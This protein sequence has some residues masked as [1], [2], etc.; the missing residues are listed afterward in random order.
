MTIKMQLRIQ[1]APKTYNPSMF[2]PKDLWK[3]IYDSTRLTIKGV[4]RTGW[5]FRNRKETLP[6]KEVFFNFNDGRLYD[7]L[8]LAD[9]REKKRTHVKF[10]GRECELA[11][12]IYE[13]HL[14]WNTTI[15]NY[16]LYLFI[17]G[18]YILDRFIDNTDNVASSAEPDINVLKQEL[19]PCINH[20]KTIVRA[21]IVR[22]LYSEGRNFYNRLINSLRE[23]YSDNSRVHE[24]ITVDNFSEDLITENLVDLIF[25]INANITDRHIGV[26]VL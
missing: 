8:N 5:R 25:S 19:S 7:I 13:E 9:V 18:I 2:M 10:V 17:Q 6:L 4:I 12:Q 16:L 21:A 22:R 15:S 1:L 14:R 3:A 26:L 24:L 11:S 23:V 20:I